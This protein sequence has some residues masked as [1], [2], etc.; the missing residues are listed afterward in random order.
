MSVFKKWKACLRGKTESSLVGWAG[1]LSV[2]LD[3]DRRLK[4]VSALSNA[5]AGLSKAC[6]LSR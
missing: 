4:S 2:L 3:V 1:G 5:A 6:N